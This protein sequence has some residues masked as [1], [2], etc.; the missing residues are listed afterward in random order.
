MKEFA[1]G[2]FLVIIATLIGDWINRI[3]LSWTARKKKRSRAIPRGTGNPPGR[4]GKPPIP[5]PSPRLPI[6][7]ELPKDWPKP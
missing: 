4:P 1:L 5:P 7:G 2:F 3:I 6:P